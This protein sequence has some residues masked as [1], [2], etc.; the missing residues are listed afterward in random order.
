MAWPGHTHHSLANA[1]AFTRAL[2]QESTAMRLEG[3]TDCPWL[4]TATGELI[5]T[6]RE[7]RL[8]I[9]TGCSQTRIQ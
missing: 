7:Q 6:L 4:G 1:H 9:N 3:Q 8:P 5:T 2:L